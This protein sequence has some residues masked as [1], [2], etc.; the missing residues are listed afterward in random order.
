MIA[1][2][3]SFPVCTA[4]SQRQRPCQVEV[5]HLREVEVHK[6]RA[7]EKAKARAELER[8]LSEQQHLQA[9]QINALRKR[10]ADM[11]ES[12]RRSQQAFEQSCYEHRQ[13]MLQV[14]QDAPLTMGATECSGAPPMLQEL[15][16]MRS[17]AKQMATE[18]EAKQR[19]LAAA[20]KRLEAQ[21]VLLEQQTVTALQTRQLEFERASDEMMRAA[22]DQ[23]Q[24]QKRESL[25]A[26]QITSDIAPTWTELSALPQLPM[27][28]DM[29]VV[30]VV[31]PA[32]ILA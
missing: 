18:N 5:Q 14:Q 30:H 3:F 7:E 6:I 11:S 24:A 2:L 25:H 4:Y 15:E 17:R 10:E 9:K 28:S 12:H 29:H 23:Q 16:S 13:T 31:R 19:E 22:R 27:R 20:E 26:L 1:G 32:P 8:V 21:R